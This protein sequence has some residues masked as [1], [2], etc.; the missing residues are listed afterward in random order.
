M[1]Y[2]E[3]HGLWWFSKN[4]GFP[5]DISLLFSRFSRWQWQFQISCHFSWVIL[6]FCNGNFLT[7]HMLSVTLPLFFPVD[8]GPFPGFAPHFRLITR[9]GK[10]TEP[11]EIPVDNSCPTVFSFLIFPWHFLLFLMSFPASFRFA[12]QIGKMTWNEVEFELGNF[13][14]DCVFRSFDSDYQQGSGWLS[15]RISCFTKIGVTGQGIGDQ[16]VEIM[17][18]R[19]ARPLQSFS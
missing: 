7:F 9:T 18:E 13:L 5:V 4:L 3:L 8:S 10:H 17:A 14:D 6:P 12:V 2:P 15:A 16:T 19:T 1:A 11:M